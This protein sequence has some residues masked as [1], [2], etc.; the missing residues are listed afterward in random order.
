MIKY[1][2][3]ILFAALLV[4]MGWLVLLGGR[5]PFVR[6]SNNTSRQNLPSVLGNSMAPT[7]FGAHHQ[8][9]CSKCGY[10][11]RFVAES[12]PAGV[13]YCGRCRS[14]MPNPLFTPHSGDSVN[15]EP[16][17]DLQR[18]DIVLV[19]DPQESMRIVKRL[20]AFPG[21]QLQIKLGDLWIN[22]QRAERTLE[23]IL[24][25][26]LLL[27]D[28]TGERLAQPD[29]TAANTDA[30]YIGWRNYASPKANPAS[31]A[32]TERIEFAYFEPWK[33][34]ETPDMKRK[35]VGAIVS[36][37]YPEN[38]AFSGFLWPVSDQI[39]ELCFIPESEGELRVGLRD[40]RLLDPTRVWLQEWK[41]TWNQQ[42][43]ISGDTSFNV[44]SNPSRTEQ[45]VSLRYLFA[46]VDGAFWM[47]VQTGRFDSINHTFTPEQTMLEWKK[48]VHELFPPDYVQCAADSLWG[49]EFRGIRRWQLRRLSRDIY[50]RGE[51]WNE[52]G[53]IPFIREV[54]G[55]YLLGDNQPISLDSRQ[56]R[57]W[58]KGVPKTWIEGRIRPQN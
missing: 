18:W 25:A 11:N 21:E 30:K 58:I 20:V 16:A 49:L 28:E 19:R 54:E 8:A 37:W 24:A 39:L 5:I 31:Q 42:E 57:D 45:D 10:V 29:P 22:G 4:L 50:F 55:Y 27:F 23:Q 47:R 15:V 44:P 53:S 33:Q 7:L 13:Y 35:Q 1:G 56:K 26:R 52:A 9:T 2:W 12:Y 36:D 38:P 41:S 43:W 48:I 3:Q 46:Y 32:A 6:L 34:T 40:P 14:L 17:K 51:E